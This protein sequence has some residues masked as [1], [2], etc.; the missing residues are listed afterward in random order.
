MV[1][2]RRQTGRL[3]EKLLSDV[4]P[5]EM[6]FRMQAVAAHVLLGQGNRIIAVNNSGHPDIIASSENVIIRVEVEA[7][8]RGT[9]EHLPKEADLEALKPLAPTDKGYFAILVCSPFPKWIVV[10]SSKFT[11]RRYKLSLSL[12][13]V[14]CNKTQTNEWNDLFLKFIDAQGEHLGDYSFQWLSQKALEQSCLIF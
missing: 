1:T 3:L 5:V 2:G 9:G 4:G 6:G 12:L 14:L 13:D 8:I 11:G 7:D 10:D